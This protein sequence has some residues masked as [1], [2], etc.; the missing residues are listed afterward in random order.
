VN[1]NEV[2][3]ENPAADRDGDK[4][5]AFWDETGS[6]TGSAGVFVLANVPFMLD[7][8]CS[9]RSTWN[10]WVCTGRRVNFRVNNNGTEPVGPFTATRDD[11]QALTLVGVPSTLTTATTTI[12]PNR[13]YTLAWG[14]AVVPPQP[15]F[16]LNRGVPGEYA[17]V[18]FP[19]A[20]GTHRVIRDYNTNS[21]L[22][23]AG[24]LAELDGGSGGW[25]YDAGT[26][27]MHLKLQVQASRD[28]ATLFVEVTP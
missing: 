12:V 1:S 26:S 18:A 13:A 21:P 3:L 6:V 14:T 20:A 25:F 8:S 15:R 5:A 16:Y 22:A 2:Y 11:G 9:Q 7:N 17:R 19:Y 23:A 28:Y 24:S 10:S 27:T 4:A